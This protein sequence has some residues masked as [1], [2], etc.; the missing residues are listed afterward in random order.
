[1]SCMIIMRGR[2]NRR[3]RGDRGVGGL[4]RVGV[5]RGMLGVEGCVGQN[6]PDRG[7]EQETRGMEQVTGDKDEQEI[8]RRGG[9]LRTGRTM[10][11][12]MAM[13]MYPL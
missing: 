2:G 1:M 4:S 10:Y 8:E 12:L 11:G 5:V 3:G 9:K 6:R 7:S 13:T